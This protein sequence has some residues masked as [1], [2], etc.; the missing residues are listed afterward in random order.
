MEADGEQHYYEQ[1]R[2]YDEESSEA[3]MQKGI[4]ILRFSDYDILKSPEAVQQR[5]YRTLTDRPPP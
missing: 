4:R 1:G 5:I 2:L 3:L